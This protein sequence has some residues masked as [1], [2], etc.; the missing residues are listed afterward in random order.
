MGSKTDWFTEQVLEHVPKLQR[1]P[2][3]ENQKELK[4]KIISYC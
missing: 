2:V 4:I 1:K 3:S